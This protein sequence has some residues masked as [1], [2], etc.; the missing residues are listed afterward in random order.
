MTARLRHIFAR[1]TLRL[2]KLVLAC[3]LIQAVIWAPA[4]AAAAG[5]TGFSPSWVQNFLPTHLWSGPV[6]PA[7]DYGLKPQW[8]YFQIVARQ[9][10]P[11]LLVLVAETNN[12]AYIDAVTVGP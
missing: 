3:T 1:G 6:D 5:S 7:V 9:T 12:Y 8:S 10:G 4:P 2:V 11:R